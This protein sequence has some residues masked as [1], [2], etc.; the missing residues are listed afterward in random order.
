MNKFSFDEAKTIFDVS[1][2]IKD[3]R[4]FPNVAPRSNGDYEMIIV[5]VLKCSLNS[6]VKSIHKFYSKVLVNLVDKKTGNTEEI[7]INVYPYENKISFSYSE[8]I[9]TLF[10]F[11]P[12]KYFVY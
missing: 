4:A 3:C 9:N 8:S 12:Q 7:M 11:Y 6:N 5:N 10:H 2:F 1:L